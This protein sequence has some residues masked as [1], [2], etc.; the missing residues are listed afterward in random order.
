MSAIDF[1]QNNAAYAK[2]FDKGDLAL[3]PAKKVLIGAHDG[4]EL[5]N[6]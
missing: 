3:P 1:S 2:Q 5:M 4:I 6:P